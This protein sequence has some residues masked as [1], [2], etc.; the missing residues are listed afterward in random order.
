M[1]SKKRITSKYHSNQERAERK[2]GI[3][4]KCR[5]LQHLGHQIAEA[6]LDDEVGAIVFKHLMVGGTFL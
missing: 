3:T 5:D 1:T 2:K 6:E 4:S